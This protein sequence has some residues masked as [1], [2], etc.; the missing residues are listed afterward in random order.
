MHPQIAAIVIS[1]NRLD[2]L[3]RCVESLRAQTRKLDAIL[4]VD[5]STLPELREWLDAQAD[6][7]PLYIQ[8]LGSAGGMHYG[9]RWALELGFDWQW[10][11]DDDVTAAPDALE[12][13][14]KGI[15]KRPDI[16]VLNS[17]SVRENDATRPSVGA[18]PW[19]KDPNDVLFGEKLITTELVYA[20]ADADG[21][22]DTIGGQLYQGTLI[23][24]QVVAQMG[25]PRIEYFV[26]GEE[27]EYGLRLMRAGYHIWMYLPSRV[28]H[29]SSGTEYIKI[30]G[31][32]YPTQLTP[33]VKRYYSIRNSFLIRREY[34]A[35][36]PFLPYVV[37]RMLNGLWTGMVT[38]PNK[39]L[40]ERLVA[41]RIILRGGLDGLA[42]K[43]G[44]FD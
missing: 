16:C 39:S 29:P 5:S 32:L 2:L 20:H 44:K 22:I 11:F 10:L 25:V 23:A 27:V 43:S 34:Y 12:Q 9:M 33:P 31:K 15:A 42:G 14:L 24:R 36:H 3:Q 17:Y 35:R 37:R 19:R 13:L 28:T 26:R 30:F 7:K 40:R 6:L 21:F 1:F 41:G 8:D 18:V 4:V 38:V